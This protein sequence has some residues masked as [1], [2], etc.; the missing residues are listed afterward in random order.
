[1]VHYYPNTG[2]RK[3]SLVERSI[4][5]YKNLFFRLL[6]RYPTEK[7]TN[8]IHLTEIAF[9]NRPNSGIFN[10]TPHR[11]QHFD[12][13]ASIVL[14]KSLL[15]YK[16]HQVASLSVFQNLKESQKLKIQDLVRI[17][18]PKQLIRKES[19]VFTPQVSEEI[20]T[21]TKVDRSRLPYIYTLNHNESKKHYAWSLMKIDPSILNKGESLK[22]EMATQKPNIVV[23]NITPKQ[24][25][26]LRNGK[27]IYHPSDVTYEVEKNGV[28]EFVD[29][30]TLLL[31]KKLFGVHTL[32]YSPHLKENPS[33]RP[34]IL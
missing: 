31:Y 15:K 10:Y 29:K 4:R 16:K 23:Q 17:R 7:Y 33:S 13:T 18:L 14:Q 26:T 6:L 12:H 32:Q 2:I 30:A 25:N 34:Y 1:M 19:A 11:V 5:S 22:H 9:N 3:V 28:K 20:F 21:I 8:L 24:Q 27:I